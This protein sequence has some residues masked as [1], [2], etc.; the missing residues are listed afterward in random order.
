MKYA[1]ALVVAMTLNAVANLMMKTGAGRL[2]G[3]R[4]RAQHG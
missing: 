3:H 4:F 2:D 1:I